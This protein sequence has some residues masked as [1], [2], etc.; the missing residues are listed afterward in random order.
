MADYDH[1][2]LADFD[3]HPQKPGRR[4]AVSKELGLE[5][6]NLNVGV[7]EEGDPLSQTHFHAH[8]SQDEFYRR[9]EASASGLDPEGEAEAN[10]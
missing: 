8:E 7:L 10:I 5:E 9:F 1:R 3:P 2:S 6:Y 4:W